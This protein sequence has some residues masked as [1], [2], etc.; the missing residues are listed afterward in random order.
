MKAKHFA[1]YCIILISVF[2][3]GRERLQVR[4]LNRRSFGFYSSRIAWGEFE[5]DS[6]MFSCSDII[7]AWSKIF[8]SNFSTSSPPFPYRKDLDPDMI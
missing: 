6:V 3:H 4:K 5:D 8:S 7:L 2:I 1:Q